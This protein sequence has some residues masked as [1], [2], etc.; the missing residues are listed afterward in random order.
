MAKIPV[1]DGGKGEVFQV[2]QFDLY[3]LCLHAQVPCSP[4]QGQGA[5]AVPGDSARLAGLHQGE[6][7]AM[8]AKDHGQGGGTALRCLHLRDIGDAPS[9]P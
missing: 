7:V 4:E 5:G 3:G 8:E 2:F 6:V 9:P 1:Q